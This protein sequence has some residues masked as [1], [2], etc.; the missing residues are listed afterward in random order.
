MSFLP[1]HTAGEFVKRLIALSSADVPTK[2]EGNLRTDSRDEFVAVRMRDVFA[3]A[4]ASIAMPPRPDPQGRG[5]AG[6][7]KPASA[8]HSGS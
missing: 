2:A 4:K 1:A 8:I 5:R 3:L 6:S 7:A